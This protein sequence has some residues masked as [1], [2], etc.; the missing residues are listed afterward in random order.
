M[1]KQRYSR[2][3]E[4]GRMTRGWERGEQVTSLTEL[5]P[6]DVLISVCHQFKAENLIRIV[7]PPHGGPHIDAKE[8]VYYEYVDCRTCERSD[9]GV[10][11]QWD[12]ELERDPWYR[13]ID[14]RPPDRSKQRIRNLPFWLSYAK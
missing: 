14:R 1:M 2:T 5:K 12:F 3:Y 7:E 6:G 13:A 10:M 9:G 4:G 8:I 11:A